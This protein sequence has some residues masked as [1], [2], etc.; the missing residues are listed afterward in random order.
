MPETLKQLMT[1]VKSITGSLAFYWE[2]RG[3]KWKNMH[4]VRGKHS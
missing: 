2:E 1:S 4:M 3:K